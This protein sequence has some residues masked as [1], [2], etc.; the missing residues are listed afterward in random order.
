MSD[1]VIYVKLPKYLHE[2]VTNRLG[3]PVVFPYRAPQNCVIRTYT[4][5]LPPGMR[6]ETA[7]EGLTAVSIPD[8][9]AKPPEVY[10]HVAKRG[11]EA[12]A[13]SI[14]DLF[15]REL[16]SDITPMVKSNL[17][18]NRLIGA[19]CE[20]HGISDG[21]VEAVRQCYYRIR[22]SYGEVGINLKD[23]TRPKE[24]L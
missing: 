2:W 11:K 18:L 7:A 16:W 17:G 19:W 24:L 10:N 1:F 13:E 3:D 20:L 6:P 23:F 4:Q 14:K 21:N 9:I 5:K 22:K 8:S 12:V 15:L